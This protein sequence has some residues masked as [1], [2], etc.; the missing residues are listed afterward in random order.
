MIID[1]D[2]KY[3]NRWNMHFITETNNSMVYEN[4]IPTAISL[5]K[6]NK[7]DLIIISNKLFCRCTKMQ[8]VRIAHI[9]IISS[10]FICKN[11]NSNNLNND[12]TAVDNHISYIDFPNSDDAFL[13]LL[14]KAEVKNQI[15][16]GMP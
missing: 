2:P 4:D 13:S 15:S 5:L 3:I 9:A 14:I 8:I 6:N 11:D 7:F 10:V 16:N 1:D 12:M